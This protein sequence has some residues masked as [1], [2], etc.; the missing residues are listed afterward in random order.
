[1]GCGSTQ[2]TSGPVEMDGDYIGEFE[3]VR[4]GVVRG[5]LFAVA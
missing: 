4:Y 3:S 2:S 1:M 5:G